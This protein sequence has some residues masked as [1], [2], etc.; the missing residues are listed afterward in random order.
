[1]LSLPRHRTQA[2]T[3]FRAVHWQQDGSLAP[4]LLVT[5]GR[6]SSSRRKACIQSPVHDR[7]SLAFRALRSAIDAAARADSGGRIS[8]SVQVRFDL[9]LML[10]H[11][12]P[13]ADSGEQRG[14]M[15]FGMR[16]C[17]LELDP[18]GLAQRGI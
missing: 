9:H 11:V 4:F 10:L 16:F 13:E 8:N 18:Q 6:S 15:A 1:M 3:V 12:V 7:Y 14:V 17:A 2:G 5:S